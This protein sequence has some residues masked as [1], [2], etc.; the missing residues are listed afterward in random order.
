MLAAL[1]VMTWAERLI[2]VSPLVF[3]AL[4]AAAWLIGRKRRRAPG[5]SRQPVRF[6]SHAWMM[7]MLGAFALLLLAALLAPLVERWAGR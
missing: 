7:L 2:A 5:F 4:I 1:R 6:V 3:L